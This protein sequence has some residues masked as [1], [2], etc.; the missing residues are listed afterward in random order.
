MT[1]VE[2]NSPNSQKLTETLNDML[3]F[4]LMEAKL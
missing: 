1:H 2:K 3:E 4:P